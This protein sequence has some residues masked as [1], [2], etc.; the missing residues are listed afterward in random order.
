VL[1]NA[2]F[3]EDGVLPHGATVRGQPVDVLGYILDREQWEL[4]KP[5]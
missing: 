2:G 5:A 1:A 4:R 3:E